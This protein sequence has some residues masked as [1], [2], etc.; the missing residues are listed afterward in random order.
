MD[1]GFTQEN[2]YT[3]TANTAAA[4]SAAQKQHQQNAQTAL[5]LGIIGAV[6]AWFPV[7]DLGGLILGILALV[8]GNRNHRFA[9]ENGIAECGNNIAARW[10]GIGSIIVSGL[11]ILFYLFVIVL[12][13][14]F[15]VGIVGS[16]GH[17]VIATLP[18]LF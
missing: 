7:S 5:I 18:E 13:V 2:A 11:S 17:E 4:P 16:V 9:E 14:I 1:A 3:E 6:I 8:R 12:A 15:A 10:C